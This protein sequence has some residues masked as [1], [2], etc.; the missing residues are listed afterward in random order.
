[1]DNALYYLTLNR[2]IGLRRTL[3]AVANNVANIDTPGY[4]REGIVFAEFVRR[5]GTGESVSMADAGASFASA[6][7]GELRVTGAALD[8]AIEGAGFFLTDGPEGPLLTRAGAFQRSPEGIV[9]NADGRALLDSGG[10]TIFLPPDAG[11][12]SVAAD[13]TLSVDGVVQA[14]I[15]VV[16]APPETLMRVGGTAFAPTEGFEPLAGARIRQ[17]ALELSNV[18]PVEEI[19]RMIAATRAYE[20][21]QT[22]VSDE[23]DRLR[24]TIQKLGQPA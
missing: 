21:A 6:R 9:V 24:D 20:Q 5:T 14:Q 11:A 22:L 8:L 16:T 17:G 23:D 15:G 13:G 2:Q 7:Q 19:A 18:N 3:D 4:R 1:M 10:G 12:V